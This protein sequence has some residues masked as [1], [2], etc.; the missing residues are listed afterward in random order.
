MR[1]SLYNSFNEL[2]SGKDRETISDHKARLDAIESLKNM[3]KS[4][5]DETFTA[6]EEEERRTKAENMDMSLIE[7]T[8]EKSMKTILEINSVIRMS[9]IEMQFIKKELLNA[10]YAM[11]QM[12]TSNEVNMNM[13]AVAPAV[14][15][16]YGIDKIFRFFYF[17]LLKVKK[18]REEIHASFRQVMLDMERLLLM[19]DSPPSA[20]PPL[21]W[22]EDGEAV[23]ANATPE[24]PLHPVVLNSNDLG[25][26]MLHIHECRTIIWE[27]RRMSLRTFR[28]IQEDLA[29]LAGERGA[30]SVQQ[31][32][33]IIARM[34]RTYS[35]MKVINAGVPMM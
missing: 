1:D 11:D 23:T 35:F 29:E 19:R 33:Q 8:K 7:Q 5:L 24:S 26:L 10:L 30:V 17:V 27:D 22:M 25:M 20:P 13:A 14:L 34:F 16:I 15:M 9:L 32:L 28:D 2:F 31:Q 18:S 21:T 6:M 12:M 4:F 3:I